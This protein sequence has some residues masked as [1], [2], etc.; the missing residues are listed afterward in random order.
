[1]QQLAA[2]VRMNMIRRGVTTLLCFA[3]MLLSSPAWAQ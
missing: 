3:A 2:E 1:L